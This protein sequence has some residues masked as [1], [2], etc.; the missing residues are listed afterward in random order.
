MQPSTT[1][2]KAQEAATFI[3]R[4]L[5]QRLQ[6]PRVAIVCGSGLGGLADAVDAQQPRA[7]IEYSSIPYFASPTGISSL[8]LYSSFSLFRFLRL[9]I[10]G[11]VHDC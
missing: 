1:H 3:Q 10:T 7:Q 2:S 4:D 6:K 8:P 5:D 9:R 11:Y